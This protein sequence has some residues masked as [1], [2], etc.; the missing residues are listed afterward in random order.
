MAAE[1]EIETVQQVVTEVRRFRSDQGLQPGQKV[2]AQL[3][4]SGT[5]LAPHEAAMRS[6]LRLQPAGEGFSATA[7]L[8]VA[9]A[10]VALDLSGAIDVEAERKRLT[11]D[12]GAAEKE[13]AQA[14]AKLGNEAFLAK[15]PEKVVEK[16]RGRLQAAEAD[17]VR[18]TA[19][20]AALPQA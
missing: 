18:I 9:G 10:T 13:K 5:A 15:A 12:L 19:Q 16:I 2:P 20:L 4:L 8:P 6:L 1:R 17:I 14:T 3:E 11:K 7:S